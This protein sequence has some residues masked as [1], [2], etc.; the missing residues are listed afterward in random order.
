MILTRWGSQPPDLP[1][2]VLRKP[3]A[4]AVEEEIVYGEHHKS[5]HKRPCPAVVPYEPY[6]EHNPY[7]Q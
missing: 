4:E 5:G 6:C 1:G 2:Y 7:E 3:L